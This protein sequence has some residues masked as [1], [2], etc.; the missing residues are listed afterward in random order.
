MT[1]N[2]TFVHYKLNI[3]ETFL[4][5]EQKIMYKLRLRVSLYRI[6]PIR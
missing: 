6:E 4:G 5:Y 2:T 3:F 1:L